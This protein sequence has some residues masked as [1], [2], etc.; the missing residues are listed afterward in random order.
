MLIERRLIAVKEGQ[1]EKLLKLATG[2]FEQVNPWSATRIYISHI[3]PNGDTNTQ[4]ERLVIEHE[5]EHKTA[6]DTSANQ[7]HQAEKKGWQEDLEVWAEIV[8]TTVGDYGTI[9]EHW[10]QSA[11][12]GTSN[13]RTGDNIA[14]IQRRIIAVKEGQTEKLLKLITGWFEKSSPGDVTRI[15]IPYV[16][17][18]YV[19]ASDGTDSKVERLVVEHESENKAAHDESADLWHAVVTADKEAWEA[20]QALWA[21]IVDTTVGEGGTIIEHWNRR[22][23]FEKQELVSI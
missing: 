15:S 22:A 11:L 16:E 3:D 5:S 14:F 21:E 1:A 2:W 10:D 12:H 18:P 6:H 8:D 9:V 20:G 23:T 13:L 17:I 7:W 19:D 4:V